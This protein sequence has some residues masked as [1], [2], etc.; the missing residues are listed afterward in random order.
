MGKLGQRSKV[1]VF[2]APASSG[3]RLELVRVVRCG[4]CKVSRDAVLPSAGQTVDWGRQGN[5]GLGG[6]W[7]G[8]LRSWPGDGGQVYYSPPED[9]AL[10]P[11]PPSSK[12]DSWIIRDS[13]CSGCG[14][15]FT[16]RPRRPAPLH[17]LRRG[18]GPGPPGG[19]EGRPFLPAPPAPWMG[20]CP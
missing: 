10:H 12:A 11:L 17:R 20:C 8:G 19:E 18:L 2:S 16:C 5:K 6:A 3:G 13:F 14:T 7:R 1:S 9:T 15:L 4:S